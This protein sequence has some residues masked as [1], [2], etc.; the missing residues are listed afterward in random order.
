MSPILK[1]TFKPKI[2][3]YSFIADLA[4][5]IV[6]IATG[7]TWLAAL[8][9][10]EVIMWLVRLI[11][12]SP[13]MLM[14]IGRRLIHMIPILLSV[15][16]LGFILLEL[17]PG[18]MF[19]KL[20]LNPTIRAEDIDNM[21]AQF[22]LDDPWY[23]KFFS[24]IGNILTGNFGQAF[25]LR[26]PV[27]TIVSQRAANTILL[28]VVSLLFSWGLSIP[29]GIWAATKQYKWQDQVIFSFCL[30]W[31]CYSQFLL[32]IFVTLFCH[33]YLW[34]RRYLASHWRYDLY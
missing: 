20:R 5:F 21:R 3:H 7:G 23:M 29:M 6:F 26:A 17:A 9:F 24:Y 19:S 2:W 13:S 4:L 33:C 31:S 11:W 27:I 25:S 16:A 22:N 14:F 10:T 15:I 28:S 30:F 18:D 32:S 1:S 12:I 8:F 34:C